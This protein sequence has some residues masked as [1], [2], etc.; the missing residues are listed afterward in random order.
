[1][2]K[3]GFLFVVSVFRIWILPVFHNVEAS[4]TVGAVIDRAYNAKPERRFKV[5]RNSPDMHWLSVR[6]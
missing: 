6:I 5:I 3:L 4:G 1:M 2:G